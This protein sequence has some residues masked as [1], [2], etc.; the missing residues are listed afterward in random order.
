MSAAKPASEINAIVDAV[1]TE[2]DALVASFSQ[3]IVNVGAGG[4]TASVRL[5][6]TLAS[7][8]ITLT[9]SASSAIVSVG[10]GG[11]NRFAANVGKFRADLG[12]RLKNFV[13][14]KG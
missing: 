10:T 6:A 4:S 7:A 1:K 11:E 12:S 8:L 5:H 9:A 2:Q 13:T 14:S 3:A